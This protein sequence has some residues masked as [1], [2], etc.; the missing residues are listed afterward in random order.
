[1]SSTEYQSLSEFQRKSGPFHH[2]KLS[3]SSWAPAPWEV[4]SAGLDFVPT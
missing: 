1:M 4:I 3:I 2:E